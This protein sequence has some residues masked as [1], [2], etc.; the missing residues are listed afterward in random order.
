QHCELHSLVDGA[1]DPIH[2]RACLLG[3]VAVSQ[4]SL[5]ALPYADAERVGPLARIELNVTS[6]GQYNQQLVQAAL[7]PMERAQKL[8]IGQPIRLR[9]QHLDEVKHTLR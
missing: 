6:L 9:R 8:G 7:W 1:N 2:N 5:A 4:V 3:E